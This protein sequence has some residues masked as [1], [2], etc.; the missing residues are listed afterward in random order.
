MNQEERRQRAIESVGLLLESQRD[1]DNDA[2]E[3]RIDQM[4]EDRSETERQFC[5]DVFSEMG[6][7]SPARKRAEQSVREILARREVDEVDDY[8]IDDVESDDDDD[9]D[10]FA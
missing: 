10:I 9:D 4:I 1:R 8:G 6:A 5:D 2:D 7:I 3:A